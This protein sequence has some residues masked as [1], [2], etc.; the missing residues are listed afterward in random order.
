MNSGCQR[1]PVGHRTII[2]VASRS[3]VPSSSVGHGNPPVSSSLIQPTGNDRPKPLPL[4]DRYQRV[5][6]ALRLSVTDACNIR[7]QYCMPDGPVRFLPRQ[8]QLTFEQIAGFVAVTASLG[9]IHYRLTGGEPLLRPQLDQLVGLLSAIEGVEEVALTTNGMLLAE[10]LPGLVEA[11]LRR[12]NISL[13]TLSE[14]AFQRLSRRAGLNRV[15]AGIEA[16]VAEPRLHVRLN[17][18]VLRDLNLDDVVELVRFARQR[19]VVIRFIEFMPLDADRSWNRQRMVAGEELRQLLSS[20]FGPLNRLASADSAQPSSDYEFPD[21]SRVGF[22]DSVTRP[23]CGTCDRLRLTADGKL[24]N[25]LFGQQEWDVAGL[26]RQLS[27]ASDV[28]AGLAVR[29]ELERL[30]D[31]CVQ[32]KAPAHG[33]ADPD[34]QPPERAMYQIGG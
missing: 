5:H 30:I 31:Q 2:N 29:R 24:R 27:E 21:G 6:R 14:T 7:C 18:L 20:H 3:S 34:F 22:I 26:L 32:A 11:G 23:F 12:V 28:A 4:V 15:L 1:N 8:H 17:A 9:V 10:Q 33:I 16:A 19:Q 25:C 13:D